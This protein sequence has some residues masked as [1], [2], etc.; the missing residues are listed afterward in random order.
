MYKRKITDP[1]SN[2][3]DSID[4]L[5]ILIVDDDEQSRESL[6]AMIEM[7]GHDVVVLDEGMKCVNRCAESRFDIIFMDYHINDLDGEVS[8]TDITEMVKECF[9]P[10]TIIYAYTGD[11]STSAIE[12]FK[13]K[14]MKGVLIKP[15]EPALICEFMK[16]VEK[17]IDDRVRLAKLGMKNKNFMYFGRKRNSAIISRSKLH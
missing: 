7:T 1:N 13:S 8:G 2:C 5:K 6:K 10:D 15:V 11:N 16:I 14:N 9:D 4:T 3:K 17:S 12:D